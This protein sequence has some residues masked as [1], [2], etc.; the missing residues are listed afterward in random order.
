M[1]NNIC[2][3]KRHIWWEHRN[4]IRCCQR[5][6]LTWCLTQLNPSFLSTPKWF[7][8]WLGPTNHPELLSGSVFKAGFFTQF[9]PSHVRFWTRF[10]TTNWG[11]PL[12]FQGTTCSQFLQ[13]CAG[14]VYEH[15]QLDLPRET[16]K[17]CTCWDGPKALDISGLGRVDWEW[18]HDLLKTGQQSPL[19]LPTSSPFPGLRLMNIWCSRQPAKV[20][21]LTVFGQLTL[22]TTSGSTESS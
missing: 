16:V 6:P 10:F 1:W 17:I 8:S 2:C 20:C 13:L 9:W 12:N 15:S 7:F 18:L 14:R 5:N 21:A 4:G 19:K 11:F 22:R 3:R